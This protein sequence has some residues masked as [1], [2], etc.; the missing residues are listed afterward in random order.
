MI[1]IYTFINLYRGIRAYAQN[2]VGPNPVNYYHDFSQWDNF[3]FGIIVTLLVWHA[4]AL[5]IYRCFVIWGHNIWVILFP[6]VLLLFSFVV[7]CITLTS[8]KHPDAVPAAVA[9]AFIQMVYP[10]NLAQ[11]ITTTSLIAYRIWSQHYKAR[12]SGLFKV[13]AGMNLLTVVRIIIESALIFTVQQLILLILLELDHP[14]QVIL[15]ATLVPSMGLVFVLMTLR[16]HFARTDTEGR[17]TGGRSTNHH[18]TGQRPG[19]SSVAVVTTRTVTEDMPMHVIDSKVP[20]DNGPYDVIF[21]NSKGQR[22]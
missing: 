19:N 3:S 4:D 1:T 15:H 10:I 9:G 14:A 17:W 20:N 6:V 5:V 18:T 2:I 12:E 13:A 8:F 7:N 22:V 16:T 21:E 11:N